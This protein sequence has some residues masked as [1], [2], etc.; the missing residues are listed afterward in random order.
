MKSKK[1]LLAS[2]IQLIIGALAIVAF[3]ILGLG[4]EN[5]TKWIITLVLSVVYVVWGIVGII[6]YT[7]KR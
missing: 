6:D 4:D 2:I 7:L 3:I 5:M 1:Q